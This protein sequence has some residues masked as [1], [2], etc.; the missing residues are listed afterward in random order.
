MTNFVQAILVILLT[1]MFTANAQQAADSIAIAVTG[2]DTYLQST[3]PGNTAFVS[4]GPGLL[5]YPQINS[6]MSIMVVQGGSYC[7]NSDLYMG[8]TF[9]LLLYSSMYAVNTAVLYLVSGKLYFDDF[10]SFTSSV[11]NSEPYL[12]A[13]GVTG[14]NSASLFWNTTTVSSNLYFLMTDTGINSKRY[15]INVFVAS[16]T[17]V[18]LTYGMRFEATI[19]VF[20]CVGDTV[21]L[22]PDSGLFYSLLSLYCY[23]NSTARGSLMTQPTSGENI[24][25]EVSSNSINQRCILY[26]VDQQSY[27]TVIPA[28]FKIYPRPTSIPESTGF[29]PARSCIPVFSGLSTASV[30]IKAGEN[31]FQPGLVAI[32]AVACVAGVIASVFF[33]N[34]Y[35][36][37]SKEDSNTPEKRMGVLKYEI[38][39][40][41]VT[42]SFLV[43]S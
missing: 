40:G 7:F 6:S 1:K 34:Y 36:Q 15:A 14:Q 37:F 42:N 13:S 2:M 11:S 18:T 24:V 22:S 31:T 5:S 28:V 19:P 21:V 30:V 12:Y 26:G 27:K 17:P 29:F 41:Q 35:S 32:G 38:V 43:A 39:C 23:V 3:Y 33:C 8:S 20:A 16:L 25:W 9:N 4:L 10:V